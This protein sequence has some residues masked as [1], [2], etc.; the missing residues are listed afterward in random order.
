M[1]VDHYFEIGK[2]HY[3]CE[4]YSYS[5]IDKK[6]GCVL[7]ADGCSASAKIAPVDFGARLLTHSLF[8]EI[9]SFLDENPN[10]FELKKDKIN[11]A[12]NENLNGFF[13]TLAICAQ[14]NCVRDLYNFSIQLLDSTLVFCLSNYSDTH[15]ITFI[16]D[17]MAIV[18]RIADDMKE[19][20]I[21]YELSY[22]SGAPFY[23]S[24][25]LDQNRLKLYEKEF[26]GEYRKLLKVSIY[27]KNFQTLKTEIT[28]VLPFEDV[29]TISIESNSVNFISVC[30]D[31]NLT[32]RQAQ[33]GNS[34]DKKEIFRNFFAYKNFQGDFVKRRMLAFKKQCEKDG[35]VHDDDI[36][37][38]TLNFG[39]N[40]G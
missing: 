15:H 37:V 6:Y 30:S 28:K 17:G 8:K 36:S 25:W 3:I 2:T 14:H 29:Y 12:T 34:V 27:D 10:I 40:H 19:E 21:V 11:F 26:C 20:N 4:D 39:E 1:N 35:I 22:E 23:L 16:G 5:V 33:T 24:Y 9:P 38:A 7:V 13:R 32:Y 31:G 18:N